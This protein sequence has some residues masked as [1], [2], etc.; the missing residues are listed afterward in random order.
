MSDTMF[1]LFVSMELELRQHL[2][3]TSASETEGVKTAALQSIVADEDVLLYWSM[4]A[5]GWNDD[6][7]DELLRLIVEHWI[8]VRGFSN[9]SSFM[10]R[11]KQSNKK[12]LQKSKGLRKTLTPCKQ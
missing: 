4:I 10:E 6:E 11:Y 7:A 8:K 1:M 12:T 9:A 5:Y 2:T 3:A